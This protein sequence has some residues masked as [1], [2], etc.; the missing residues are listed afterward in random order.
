MSIMMLK[1]Q[2]VVLLSVFFL[3]FSLLVSCSKKDSSRRADLKGRTDLTVL[4][5]SGLHG[6][7][8]SCGCAVIDM[9]G[10]G[11]M[12][13]YVKRTKRKTDNL[14]F[15]SCGDDFSLDLSFSMDK[16]D[17]LME[18]YELMG[19]DVFTTGEIEYIFGL[20]YLIDIDELFSFDFVVSNLVYSENRERVF[21]PAYLIKELD[22]GLRV[23]ITGLLDDSVR[24]P[25][26]I[27]RSKF[28]LEPAVDTLKAV[29]ERMK[30]E[31]DLLIVLSHMELDATRRVLSEV[32]LFDIAVTGHGSQRID[33][34]ERVG[35]TLLLG[36]GGDGKYIGKLD[37]EISRKGEIEYSSVKLVPL[38]KNIPIHNGVKR[39]FR[40]H[41][42]ELTDKED[43]K[44]S[45]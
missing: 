33:K 4:F 18:C 9:G 42:I 40:S 37:L 21:K 24:F 26:Y 13:T 5:T 12:A 11:R 10:L 17:L 23:G 15:L 38:E 1:K 7:I 44:K 39:V 20:D 3:I 2:R 25:D 29:A 22:T 16:A 35:E 19:L 14:I 8:R 31:A 45:Y 32:P 28:R 27:D 36:V 6:K 30:D 43:S 41:G 34:I